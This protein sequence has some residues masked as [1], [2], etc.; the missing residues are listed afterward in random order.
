MEVV[1]ENQRP[2]SDVLLQDIAR[3]VMQ[4]EIHSELAWDTA[5]LCLMDALGCA[6]LALNYTH[7][8]SLLGPIVPGTIVPLGARVPG[9][10]YVLDPIKASFDLGTMIRWLDY[11]DTWLAAEWGHP[12][13]NLGGILAVA[14][15]VSRRNEARGGQPVFMKTVLE[16]MIKAYEIQGILA[17]NTSF[18]QVGFDHVALVKIASAATIMRLLGGDE[19]SIVDV[20]SQSFVDGQ[21]LRTYRHRPNTGSR[22]SWAAGDATARAVELCWLT[23]I[24]EQGYPSVLSTPT[25]GFQD[26]YFKG[27]AL[28]LA[29]PLGSYVMENILFKISYPAEFHGQTAVECALQLHRTLKN[30]VSQI[31]KITIE[32]QASAMRI[33]NKTGPLHNPADRDH[34]IQYMVAYTLIHGKLSAE[35]YLDEAASDPR[36]DAL[37]EKIE[38]IHNPQFS[39]DYLDPDKRSIANTLT[40]TLESGERHC[41]TEAY[42]IGHRRRREEGIPLLEQKFVDNLTTQFSANQTTKIIEDC[43]TW[44]RLCDIPVHEFVQKLVI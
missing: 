40:I 21:A 11:N 14:D 24:G 1:T 13:D 39:E 6:M 10:P 19:Q 23:M 33:I 42:P 20:L 31:K 3:Y 22:K 5:R 32:T 9:T 34:S 36:I 4:A 27:K 8:T 15:Y 17:L 29:Q 37:R 43:K 18:N 12:S 26:I 25:W 2:Q 44:Q 35:A 7:C 30:K 16:L 38:V 41:A 28:S